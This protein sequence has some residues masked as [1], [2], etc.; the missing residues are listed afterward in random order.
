MAAARIDVRP[1]KNVGGKK[2]GIVR[3]TPGDR[4]KK[5]AATTRG[6]AIL[7]DRGQ[8]TFSQVGW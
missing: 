2:G 6:D 7:L 3:I 8:K 1:E 4:R 5:R